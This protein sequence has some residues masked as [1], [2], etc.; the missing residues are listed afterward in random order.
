MNGNVRLGITGIEAIPIS[1]P[2]RR[3]NSSGSR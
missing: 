1:I 2:S 3:F